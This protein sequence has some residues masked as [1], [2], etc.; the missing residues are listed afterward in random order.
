MVERAGSPLVRFPA[1]ALEA[2]H[3][4][5]AR[6]LVREGLRVA[7]GDL[8]RI[9]AVHIEAV[10]GLVRAGRGGS[11]V[12]LPGAVARLEQR[13]LTVSPAEKASAASADES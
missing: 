3:P 7:R 5:L 2:A 6:R 9:G 13:V 8:R 11:S 1:A 10:L 4:A 12:D